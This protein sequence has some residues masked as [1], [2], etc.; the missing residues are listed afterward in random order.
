MKNP[1]KNNLILELHVPDF[2]KVKEFYSKLGF[3]VAMYDK[4]NENKQG[5]LTMA[6]NDDAG[7]TIL[8][9]YG[10]D[11]RVYT[12]SFFKQF[13]KDTPRGYEVGIT[14][15]VSNIDKMYKQVSIDSKD[16]IVRDLIELNDHNHKWKDFRM[17][18]PFGFYLR[19]T[20]LL[21]WGQE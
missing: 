14:I 15:P 8:N 10:S 20:E 2:E 6:R 1:I 3:V 17:V 9:F 11:E 5:Y 7:N 19:F 21:D 18:D 4:P 16:G 12:Q 13:P